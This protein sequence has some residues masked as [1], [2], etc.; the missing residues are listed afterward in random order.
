MVVDNVVAVMF[1][2]TSDCNTSTEIQLL[3]YEEIELLEPE[4]ILLLLCLI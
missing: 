1:I 2:G 3:L 4:L